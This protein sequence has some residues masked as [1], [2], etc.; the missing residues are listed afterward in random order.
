MKFEVFGGVSI[1]EASVSP[2]DV[3]AAQA[4]SQ[5]TCYALCNITCSGFDLKDVDV[6]ILILPLC[7]HTN[8]FHATSYLMLTC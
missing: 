7:I 4:W 1:I 6:N 2:F 3:T 5:S 8:R